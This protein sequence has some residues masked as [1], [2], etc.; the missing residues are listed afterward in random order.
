LAGFVA[1]GRLARGATS[2]FGSASTVGGRQ[3][4]AAHNAVRDENPHG[5]G[6]GAGRPNRDREEL[7]R[8]SRGAVLRGSRARA[9]SPAQRRENPHGGDGLAS[10]FPGDR[11]EKGGPE[12]CVATGATQLCCA[13]PS[14]ARFERIRHGAAAK[15]QLAGR[16]YKADGQ[17]YTL[18]TE[19]IL[20]NYF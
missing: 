10:D 7:G 19:E 20:K 8:G 15:R 6:T 13:S 9:G 18:F 1:H 17:S 4:H 2:T 11:A 3:N 16:E 5:I 12:R 14:T